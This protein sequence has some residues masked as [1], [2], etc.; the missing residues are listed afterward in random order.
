MLIS[1]FSE[2]LK[3]F[4]ILQKTGIVS[5]YTLKNSQFYVFNF[6]TIFLID[7]IFEAIKFKYQLAVY[8]QTSTTS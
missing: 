6:K 4:L 5:H 7:I 1:L 3:L 2:K 8:L